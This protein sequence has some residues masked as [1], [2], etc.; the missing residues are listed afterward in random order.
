M[1]T[2]VLLFC[3]VLAFLSVS[4]AP[5]ARATCQDTCLTNYNTVQGDDALISLTTGIHDTAI[6][7]QS[8]FSNTTGSGN[9][10]TGTSALYSNT[11]GSDNTAIGTYAML[12]NTTG[13]DNTATGF[14]TLLSNI[15][16]IDNTATGVAALYSNTTGDSNTAT[17]FFA[18]FNNT[19][20]E[21]NTATG[22]NALLSNTT[23]NGNTATG[24]KALNSNSTGFRNTANGLQ[25]LGLNTSGSQNTA[26]GVNSLFKNTTGAANVAIGYNA[27]LNNM[28]GGFNTA[29]GPAAGS[30]LTTGSNNI[31][32]ANKGIAAEA[33][34]IRI[35]TI[36]TQTNTYIA[37]ISGVT[38][39]GGVGVIVGSDGQLGTVVSSER[40]KDAVKPMDKA[41]EA[42][43]SLKPVTFRYKHE[44]DPSSIPQF[45]LVAE[46]VEKVNPDLVARDE[47]GRPY[48]VRYEAVNAMLLNEF[49]KEHRTVQELKSA[50]A[51]QEA[52]IAHQQKQIEALTAGLQKVSAQVE[53][54]KPASQM[55][56]NNQ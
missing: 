31:D 38:V 37:G 54:S 12:N 41:S 39:A 48:T 47:Q 3:I 27:L 24:V 44:L 19:I 7:F 56:A 35:G 22:D 13:F 28:T 16:G 49:L 20:G 8:L 11:R 9:T 45:G 21:D 42:I 18:L 40:F 10:A 30:Q 36:G 34:T 4:V 53:V 50:S 6:G 46:E 15:T 29:V 51:K 5:Q 25:A 2:T 52:I 23:G 17:G 55:V 1:K 26:N 43:L 33:N 14:T 32:I